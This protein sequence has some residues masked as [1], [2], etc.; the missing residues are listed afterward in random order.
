MQGP[1]AAAVVQ[2]GH[3]ALVIKR[4][5][6]GR[7]YAVLP[8]GSI[9]AGESFKQAAARGLGRQAPWKPEQRVNCSSANTSAAKPGTS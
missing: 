6:Y 7:D 5:Y 8:G 1:R 2:R 4:H 9:E 3:Q